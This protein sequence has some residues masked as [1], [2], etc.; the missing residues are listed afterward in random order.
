M[1]I[2]A[3]MV[4]VL[5]VLGSASA[6]L[7]DGHGSVTPG[8]D[9]FNVSIE[10]VSPGQVLSSPP[11]TAGPGPAAEHDVTA[12]DFSEVCSNLVCEP[13]AQS[14]LGGMHV[15]HDGDSPPLNLG[16]CT[17]GENGG[18]AVTPGMVSAAF[19]RVSLPESE[20]QV[21]PPNGRT[22]VN[23][24]TNFYTHNGEFTRTVTL[25]GRRVELRIW[26]ARYGWRFGDGQQRWTTT[27]GDR[28]PHLEVTHRYLREG[29]VSP[30]VDTTYAAE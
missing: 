16:W 29:R 27:P 11:T 22:L 30:S 4:V 25:L 15:Y 24:D 18:V 12:C 19:R 17:V 7:G 28:Y 2:V 1:K 6:A 26:P 9:D 5:F 21:Q 8:D 20:L 23:F 13:D 3:A 10:H 14:P